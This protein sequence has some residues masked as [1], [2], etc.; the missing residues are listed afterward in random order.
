MFLPFVMRI[1]ARVIRINQDGGAGVT[2]E[3][4]IPDADRKNS[5]YCV[6]YPCNVLKPLKEKLNCLN[7]LEIQ[8][9]K[10]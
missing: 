3:G 9:G 2:T 5:F 4:N 6:Y 7:S 10:S 1:N 8:I